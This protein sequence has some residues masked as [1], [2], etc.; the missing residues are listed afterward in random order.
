M[1]AIEELKLRLADALSE[2]D[3]VQ[4]SADVLKNHWWLICHSMRTVIPE[5]RELETGEPQKILY[6]R[7]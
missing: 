5:L 4:P 2:A 7:S 1:T 6:E 3:A